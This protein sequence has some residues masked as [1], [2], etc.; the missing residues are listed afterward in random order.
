MTIE[1]KKELLITIWRNKNGL[2]Y[3]ETMA[4]MTESELHALELESLVGSY[5]VGMGSK[6]VLAYRGLELIGKIK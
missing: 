4:I 3:K 1:R 6:Y 5:W 2:T